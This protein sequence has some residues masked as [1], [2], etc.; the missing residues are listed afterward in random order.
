MSDPIARFRT[1]FRAAAKAG[2]ALPEAMALATVDGRGRPSV[3]YVLLKTAGADGFVFYT[4]D[5]SRKGAEM[6][7][8]S[9][10]ALALYWD[11]TGQQVRIEGRVRLLPAADADRYWAERPTG[12]RL[13]S[14]ASQQSRPLKA[15]ADLLRRYAELEAEYPDGDIP[16]PRHWKG[17]VVVPDAIEFWTRA[18][19]RLHKRELFR[20]ARTKGAAWTSQLLQP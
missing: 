16:R 1:W 8:N 4:N 20:R 18:E 11:T 14:A 19:P 17:Y 3:R 7:G 9:R 12:S 13:A 15:R 2:V 6:R 10:V 5:N